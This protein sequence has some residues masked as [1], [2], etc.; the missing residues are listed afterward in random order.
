[1]T[2]LI[3]TLTLIASALGY[4][5][6]QPSIFQAVVQA[7]KS[8]QACAI[9]AVLYAA[10]E[11]AFD[12]HPKAYSWDARSHLSCGYWQTPC[13]T[14]PDTLLG[15]ARLW[16]SLRAASLSQFGSLVGLAGN[17]AA[18]RQLTRARE[19]EKEDCL[20]AAHWATPDSGH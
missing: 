17:T 14:L 3:Y 7:C 6:V 8:D 16:V 10:H 11:S 9:D 12:A 2:D 20:F 4:N 5:H 19:A 18:G 13:A 15:Q 1:M